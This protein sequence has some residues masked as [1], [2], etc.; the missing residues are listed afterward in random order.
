MLEDSLTF[1][2]PSLALLK[3]DKIPEKKDRSAK[4]QS[5]TLL[6][7][8]FMKSSMYVIKI[9]KNKNSKT[10]IVVPFIYSSFT[11]ISTLIFHFQQLHFKNK[12]LSRIANIYDGY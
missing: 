3:G 5:M 9:V 11:L 8:I 10:K 2:L 1:Q 6:A 7:L 4:C 12:I